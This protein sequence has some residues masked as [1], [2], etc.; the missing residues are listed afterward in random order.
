[1]EKYTQILTNYFSFASIFM[2]A[3]SYKCIFVMAII[4]EQQVVL[5]VP[6]PRSSIIY[7]YYFHMFHGVIVVHNR[8]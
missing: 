5:C 3:C 2:Y 8:P 1:M 7:H 4:T 6:K